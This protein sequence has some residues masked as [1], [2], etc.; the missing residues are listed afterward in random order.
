MKTLIVTTD[1]AINT[2]DL[3]EDFD[4]DWLKTQIDCEWLE[5]VRPE[6]LPREYIM[7]VDEMGK[8]KPNRIN[9]ICSWLYGY[10]H[11]GEP[12]VGNAA[13]LKIAFV[14]GERDWCGLDDD[15][16]TK[17]VDLLKEGVRK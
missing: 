5:M 15:D 2:I 3:P 17:L 6:K 9:P 11:H 13:F 10:E 8:M 7:L 1:N 14:N 4:A 16:V 12:I